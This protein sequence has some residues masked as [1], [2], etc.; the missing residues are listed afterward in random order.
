MSNEANPPG[1]IGSGMLGF[2]DP[3]GPFWG[4]GSSAGYGWVKDPWGPGRDRMPAQIWVAVGAVELWGGQ[5]TIVAHLQQLLLITSWSWHLILRDTELPTIPHHPK[6]GKPGAIACANRQ[7]K[8]CLWGVSPLNY[9]LSSE[10]C[11]T[12]GIG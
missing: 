11:S 4:F 1:E 9:W 5:A 2:V 7:C 12:F 8:W 6:S 10:L 3:R